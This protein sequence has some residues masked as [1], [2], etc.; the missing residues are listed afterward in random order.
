MAAPL[1]AVI[2]DN[3]ETTGSYH[4][5]IAILTILQHASNVTLLQTGQLLER[6]ANWMV[7]NGC[8]RPG[9]RNFL[10]ILMGLRQEGLLDAIVMYTNQS[11]FPLKQPQHVPTLA[12][13]PARCV[14]YML[15]YLAKKPIFDRIL[16]R[17]V[18][19]ILQNGTYPKDF[20]RVLQQFPG[21]P[22]DIRM[23]RFIDD[24]AYKM[25]IQASHVAKGKQDDACWVPWP[26]HV[27]NLKE[28]EVYDCVKTCFPNHPQIDTLLQMIYTE[29]LKYPALQGPT[30]SGNVVYETT[31]MLQKTYGYVRKHTHLTRRPIVIELPTLDESSK[32]DEHD[33]ATQGGDST[34]HVQGTQSSQAHK[35]NGGAVERK[36]ASPAATA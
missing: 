22:Y 9:L 27:R 21:R 14:A 34:K 30:P 10:S 33:S 18:N 15:E 32:R 36:H 5:L 16:T 35:A 19:A 3:D 20:R 31:Q 11:D 1:R 8:F 28:E 29:Y 17:P 4:L 23:M 24:L 7:V 6:L 25:F 2:L 12:Q 26:R 13:S